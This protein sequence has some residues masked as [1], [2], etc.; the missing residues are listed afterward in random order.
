MIPGLHKLLMKQCR[1]RAQ[2]P[3]RLAVPENSSAAGASGGGPSVCLLV[4]LH[5]ARV[6][7]VFTHPAALPKVPHS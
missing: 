6:G 3:I 2:R 5:Q 1:L 4:A 7:R